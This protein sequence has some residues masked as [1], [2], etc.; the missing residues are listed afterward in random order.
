MIFGS[1]F[2][3]I[4]GIDLGLERAGMRC[5]WQIERD[6]KC[7]SVLKRHWPDVPVHRDVNAQMSLRVVDLIAGG[8]PCQP[9]SSASH[10]RKNGI[11]DNRW[12]WPPMRRLVQALRPAWVL[13]ENVPHFDGPGLEAVVADLG[14]DGYEVAPPLEIPACAFGFDHR[15]S[16]NWILGYSDRYRESGVSQH[17]EVAVLPFGGG[18]Q[19]DELGAED[20]IPGWMDRLRMLGNAVVPDQAEWIGR[21]IMKA[22]T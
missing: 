9:F 16:R 18:G 15:R 8:P 21:N 6:P 20:G 22:T 13:V 1:V 7:R 4:G 3:G 12:L 5:A 19:P 2:S 10:G 17:E 11:A 14:S